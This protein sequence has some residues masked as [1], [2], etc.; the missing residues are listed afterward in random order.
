MTFSERMKEVLSQGAAVSKDIAG[1]VGEKAQDWGGKG[2]AASQS[3]IGKAGAKAQEWGETGV[4]KIE[5]KQLEGQA[6]RCI[7]K[8]GAEVYTSF[9]DQHSLSVTPESPG[10]KGIL[11]ELAALSAEIEKREQELASR[12]Q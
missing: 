11:E 9:T 4:L 3:L 1:K 7:A 6:Q 8:L 2:L 10:I 5:I 12:K